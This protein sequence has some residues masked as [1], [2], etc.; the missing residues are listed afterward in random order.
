MV[1]SYISCC[2]WVK[3]G[4]NQNFGDPALQV[5]SAKVICQYEVAK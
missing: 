4:A 3:E 2:T 5:R 1:L